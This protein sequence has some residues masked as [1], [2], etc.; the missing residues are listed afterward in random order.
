MSNLRILHRSLIALAVI[1]F[2]SSIIQCNSLLQIERL[3]NCQFRIERIEGTKIDGIEMNKFHSMNDLGFIN[4]TKILQDLSKGSLSSDFEVIISVNNPNK[5]LASME[6]FEYIVMLD[7][8]EVISGSLNDRIEIPADKSIEFPISAS[9]NI[10]KLIKQNSVSALME[11]AN[12]M[13]KGNTIQNRVKIKVKPYIKI[14]KKS[15]KYPGF[16]EIKINEW[17]K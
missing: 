7:K 15:L 8:D 6:K 4:T 10:S 12:T 13:S 17:S 16:I 5:S 2:I 1:L 3:K 9:V 11:L 14:G